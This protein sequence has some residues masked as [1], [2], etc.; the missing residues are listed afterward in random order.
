M[1]VVPENEVSRI[2]R[3]VRKNVIP[4]S[5]RIVEEAFHDLD[6][7]SE[8]MIVEGIKPG[9]AL[10]NFNDMLRRVFEHTLNVLEKYEEEAYAKQVLPQICELRSEVLSSIE[11]SSNVEIVSRGIY[12]L[13]DD[14]WQ[15][16]LSRSQ[17]RKQ[18]GGKDWEWEIAGM[19]DLA[20]IPFKMQSAHLRTDFLIPSAVAFEHDRTKAILLSAKRSLRE[21]WAHL[22]EEIQRTRA[23]NAYLAVAEETEALPLSKVNQIWH[24][25]VHL[26]VWDHVK[27]AF[28]DH[29]GV[30][31]YSQFANEEIQALQRHW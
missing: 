31:S 21:R 29:P 2:V 1:G 14:L 26:L 30:M 3:K 5:E 16:M 23:A 6:Y 20:E 13:Y 17:S 15:I 10:A 4:S 27:E 18:R 12:H 11:G 25:N 19:L 24:Y 9:Y 7:I 28:A 8:T 22:A